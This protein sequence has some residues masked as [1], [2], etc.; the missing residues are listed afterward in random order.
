MEGAH[1]MKHGLQRLIWLAALIAMVVGSGAFAAQ[2]ARV[3]EPMHSTTQQD[4]PALVDG[5]TAFA[6]DLYHAVA[7]QGGNLIFSPYSVSLALAMTYAGAAGDTAQQMADTLHFT[8]PPDQFHP[9]FQA[10]DASLPR[11]VP[12]EPEGDDEKNPDQSFRLNIA[13]ALWGQEGYAFLP[14]FLDVVNVNYGA[15]LQTVDFVADTEGARQTI[16]GW[17]SD[18]TEERIQDLIPAGAL[19]PD[20]R[21][22]LTNAIYF[23]AAW[24]SQFSEGMTTDGSF[25]L[26]DGSTVEVPMMNQVERFGYMEGDGYQAISLDYEGSQMAMLIV[27]PDAG[28][29]EAVEASMD[30]ATFQAVAGVLGIGRQRISLFVPRWEYESEFSLAEVLATMGMPLAFSDAADFSG[31][32]GARD[33][34]ISDVIHKAFVQVDEEGTEAAAATAVIMEVTAAMP[35]EPPLEVR[36]DRPFMYF[37]YDYASGSILFMGRVLTPAG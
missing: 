17:V 35:E 12:G 4:I 13:N 23:N 30:A 7:G 2:A 34:K 29:F 1:T 10:L 5:N 37:I 22:V 6:F 15:G 33:L 28:Q 9:A 24:L 3:E 8:L 16:N 18:Q 27:L 31:M 11:I 14:T 32:T 20:S 19:G 26:L 25:T 36:V 21:L